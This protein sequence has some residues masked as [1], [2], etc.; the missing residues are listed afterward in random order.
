MI[1]SIYEKDFIFGAFY[2]LPVG[3]I[4]FLKDARALGN[5]LMDSFPSAAPKCL[6]SV[7]NKLL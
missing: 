5:R 2:V 1:N 6:N 7:V 3:R 4:L